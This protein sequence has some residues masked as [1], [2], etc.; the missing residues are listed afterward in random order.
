MDREKL[1]RIAKEND[2]TELRY[3]LES[4]KEILVNQYAEEALF[5][6]SGSQFELVRLLLDAG[7]DESRLK[8]TPSFF[9][10]AFGSTSDLKKSI[11]EHHDLEHKDFWQRTPLLLAIQVG[12][13]EKVSL[14]L[15]LGANR[16]VTG[17]CGRTP[18]LYAVEENNLQ[19]LKWLV[20]QGF[21]IEAT[22]EFLNTPLTE[23]SSWGH[24]DI[25]K[26]L[27]DIG[28]DIYKENHIPERAIQV[29][30][31]VEIVQILVACGDDI[32][33][34]CKETH[35]LL[36]GLEVHG[37]PQVTKEEY[38]QGKS[39]VYGIS[40]PQKNNQ[41]FWI[42]MIKSGAW[43]WTPR[44]MFGDE[45]E[46]ETVWSYDRFGRSTN[47]LPDG[48]IIE[49]AGEHEDF[50]DPDFCIYN[51]VFVFSGKDNID[52]YTYPEEVFPDTDFHTATLVGEYIY[53]IGNLGYPEERRPGFTPVYRLNINSMVI[54]TVKTSGKMPGW[55]HDH[56]AYFD[57]KLN[58]ITV[59]GGQQLIGKKKRRSFVANTNSYQ[60]CLKNSRWR[61]VK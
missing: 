11:E 33:D 34:I 56:K 58:V 32:N 21:D 38:Y 6:A 28:A 15:S 24:T 55:I 20:E 40:N 14:L 37:K 61:V 10:I 3:V 17:H 1:L 8:W 52:I 44:D 43:A 49:I 12:N 22:N 13:I 29:A 18:L 47:I 45:D 26:Y 51:D 50:Y 23:A 35:A 7:V 54:D 59:K 46:S 48:R 16:N 39:P 36:L 42:E 4:G 27:V 41:K 31:N 60:L 9:K 53:I 5:Y 25:V 30:S 57:D 19:M 2:L